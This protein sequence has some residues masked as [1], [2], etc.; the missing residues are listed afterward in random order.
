MEKIF[1]DASAWVAIFS[2]T[3][4]NHK[5]AA[6]IFQELKSSKALLYTSDYIL[7]E[8]IT[9]ILVRSSH[10]LSLIAGESLFSSEIIKVI[11]VC[12]EYLKPAWALYKKYDDKKFSFT[13]VTSF[14]IIKDLN[15]KKAFSFDSDFTKAGIELINS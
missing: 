2:K 13:D 7:D 11:H 12:P 9:T 15:I 5:K 14:T 3:D 10:A 4:Q 6:A 1:V 8:T